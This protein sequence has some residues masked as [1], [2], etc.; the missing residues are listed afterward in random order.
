MNIVTLPRLNRSL[1]TVI[2]EL[3]SF[4]FY[5]EKLSKVDVFLVPLGAA[6]GWQ[7]YG[8]SGDINIPA[9]SLSRLLK[10]FGLFDY[11]IGSLR[12][13][14]RHEWAHAIADNHRGLF[15][16]RVFTEAFYNSHSS[17]QKYQ[18]NPFYFVSSY[19]A[20]NAS[21]CFAEDFMYFLKFKGKL[22]AKFDT[23]FIRKQ[24]QFIKLLAVAIKKGQSRW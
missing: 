22:P 1:S 10:L 9:V 7:W 24:W 20:T 16:S 15:H 21:E 5:D 6:L 12:D 19:A 13:I 17:K 8:T 18:Y 14:L 3:N 11:S 4:G 2:D 23:P